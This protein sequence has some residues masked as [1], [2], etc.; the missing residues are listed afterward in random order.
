MYNGQNLTAEGDFMCVGMKDGRVEFRFD[1]GSGPAIIRSDPI[2][3]N[4]WH[5][6]RVL[7]DQKEG[8]WM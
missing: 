4:Q 3:L 6:I 8:V 7:R 5:T 1:V 2:D